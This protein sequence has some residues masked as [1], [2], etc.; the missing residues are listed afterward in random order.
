MR[1]SIETTEQ[2]SMINKE[3][4]KEKKT[5]EDLQNA[6]RT[7]N[8]RTQELTPCPYQYVMLPN[9]HHYLH[10]CLLSKLCFYPEPFFPR[11][12]PII[13]SLCLAAYVI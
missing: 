2:L 5:Q 13:N 1:G 12:H 4:Q 7:T 9:S 3:R 8:L 11:S 10:L 6:A